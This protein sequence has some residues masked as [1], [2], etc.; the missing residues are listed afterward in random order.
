MGIQKDIKEPIREDG[1]VVINVVAV[2]IFWVYVELF[3]CV[4]VWS[5]PVAS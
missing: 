1:L 3:E 4:K 5:F 2:D